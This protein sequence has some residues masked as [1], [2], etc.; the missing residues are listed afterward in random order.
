MRYG[1]YTSVRDAV[2]EIVSSDPG[3]TVWTPHEIRRRL[4]EE[5]SRT[6][7]VGYIGMVCRRL[8]S[9]GRIARTGA[10]DR[11]LVGGRA[12]RRCYR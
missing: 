11:R 12:Y 4:A 5:T 1:P 8:C 10:S 7:P 2:Y 3:K 9:E 6:V